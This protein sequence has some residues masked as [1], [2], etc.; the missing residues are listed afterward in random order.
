MYASIVDNVKKLQAK[1]DVPIQVCI[2]I[3]VRASL[4]YKVTNI[5]LATF[6]LF[7]LIANSVNSQLTTPIHFTSNLNKTFVSNSNN[8]FV[9]R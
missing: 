1:I 2:N 6:D 5:V 8:M 9:R 7:S 3:Y 4:A